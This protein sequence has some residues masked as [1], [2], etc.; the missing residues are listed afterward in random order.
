MIVPSFKIASYQSGKSFEAYYS[1]SGV[2][3]GVDVYSVLSFD[4][5]IIA[6]VGYDKVNGVHCQFTAWADSDRR[7]RPIYD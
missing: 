6:E 2:R 7:F 4:V 5:K 3:V 1:S